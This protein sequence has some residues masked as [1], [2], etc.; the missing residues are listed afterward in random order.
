MSINELIKHEDKQLEVVQYDNLIEQIG[1]LLQQGRTHAAYAVNNILVKTYWQIGK[2]I[3]EF[4]QGGLEK[5]EYGSK[6][7]DKLSIDLTMKYGKGFSRSN[8]FYIRAFYIKF[9]KIQTL[10]GQFD[11]TSLFQL[12]W[13]HYTEIIKSD[14]ELEIMF[15]TKQCKKEN[16]SIRELR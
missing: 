1:V 4:E 8:L 11:E 12:S 3:V 15:Y 9:S 2:Y 13:G 16:W 10:S 7:L 6:L 14:N 5:P